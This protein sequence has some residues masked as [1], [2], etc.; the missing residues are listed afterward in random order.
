MVVTL[1][2]WP[3]PNSYS[4]NIPTSGSAGSFWEGRGDR[5]HCGIDIYAPVGS[6]VFSI[7][8]GNVIDI[9][10]FT[11]QDKVPYWNNTRHVL[12]ENKTGLV[13]KYAELGDMAVETGE[14]IK[15]GQLIGHVGLVLDTRKITPDSPPYIQKLKKRENLSMLH[16]ELYSSHP[17]DTDD[18][19]GGNWFGDLKPENLLD[20]AD[21]LR[22]TLTDSH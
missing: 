18:Y 4:E 6:D 19:L 10:T 13:C 3:V 22:S 14:S 17:S 5:R 1:K 12:I 20:P 9:G 8:G 2:H 15:A 21:Y 16:F 11:S 7:E